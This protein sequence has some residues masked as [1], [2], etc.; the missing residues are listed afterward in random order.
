MYILLE[1]CQHPAVLRL[2]FFGTIILDI[3]TVVIPIGLIVML[4]IDFTKAVIA[5]NDD[6]AKK[7]T[8]LVIKRIL[9]AVIIFVIPWIINVL[10]TILSNLGVNIGTDY[11]ICITNAKSGNFEYY[12][13]LLEEEE[14]LEKEKRRQEIEK[15]KQNSSNGD[16]SLN[17]GMANKLISVIES[18]IGKT[19]RTKYGAPSGSAW[20]AYF[21]T[22]SMKQTEYNGQNLFY[23]IIEKEQKVQNP[24]GAGCTI[25]NFNTSNNLKFHYSQYYAKKYNKQSYTPK[26]GDTIYFNWKSNWDGKITSCAGMY[27]P[28]DHIGFVHHVKDG[29]V[30][31][32]D[33]NSRCQGK[34]SV[35]R[36]CNPNENV[37][38]LNDV[39]IMGYGSWYN[40]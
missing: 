24:G 27:N 7:S 15:N 18:E 13:K 10:M 9:Y 14:K 8:K 33:G 26:P 21:V 30:Y 34:Y 36:V 29:K 17:S 11:N 37:R 39:N 16:S 23:D 31:I 12:D 3:I 6:G 35:N 22:W 4:L 19:D 32:L 38:D 1:A 2:I 5:S 40:N 20:C 25:Y 28:T